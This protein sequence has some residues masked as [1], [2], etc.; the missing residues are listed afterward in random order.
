MGLAHRS[1]MRKR[2]SAESHKGTL[3]IAAYRQAIER[4]PREDVLDEL[5]RLRALVA[6]LQAALESRTIIELA[7][8]VLS[9]RLHLSPPQA[10]E[11]LRFAAR[12]ERMRVQELAKMVA[13]ETR[14]PQQIVRALAREAVW[15][16]RAQRE[17]NDLVRERVERMLSAHEQQLARLPA[18]K[19]GRSR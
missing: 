18:G 6:Q 2:H 17:R 5:V 13:Y 16:S 14:T 4:L 7:K 11:L 9:E 10:F 8:G 15:R 1:A 12:S 19:G 3:D